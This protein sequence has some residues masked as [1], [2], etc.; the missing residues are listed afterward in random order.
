MDKRVY[1]KDHAKNVSEAMKKVWQKRREEQDELE[2][3]RAFK[4]AIEQ[5]RREE[6]G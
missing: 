6:S 2:E 5:A 4:A 1:P 3:L